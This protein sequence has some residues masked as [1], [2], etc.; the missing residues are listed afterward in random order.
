MI[1][2]FIKEQENYSVVKW[3]EFFEVSTS[4]YYT[5]ERERAERLERDRKYREEVRE[6][7]NSGKGTY[8][9]DRVCG[10][11]RRTGMKANFLKVKRLMD[12]M[13]LH[14]IHKRRR[15]RSLTDSRK[16]RGDGYENLVRDLE[17]TEPFGDFRNILVDSCVIT[18]SN[19]GLGIQLRDSGNV[20]HVR[21]TNIH[22]ET[23]RFSNKWWGHAEPIYVTSLDRSAGKGAGRIRDVYFG[24]IVCNGSNG[25]YISGQK[26]RPVEDVVF[27]NVSVEMKARPGEDR[28]ECDRRP[29]IGEG[30]VRRDSAGIYCADAKNVTL[31][32][33]RVTWDGAPA[34]GFGA[35]LE[36]V[37]SEG[38][39]IEDFTGRASRKGIKAIIRRQA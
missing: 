12:E 29:C 10:I 28:G 37:G 34:E 20:E 21:Y 32:H 36:V 24:G 39:K 6:A 18:N 8:G 35:A 11:M 9:V 13:D 27:D 2:S 25:A 22:I 15:Q 5:W 23:R 38:L 17:I 31:R 14:S 1:F 7:F 3:A 30:L 26:D 4:G 33:V 19:R 16:S